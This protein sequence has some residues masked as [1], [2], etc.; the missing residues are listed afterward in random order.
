MHLINRGVVINLVGSVV[1]RIQISLHGF[2]FVNA[3]IDVVGLVDLLVDNSL[4]SHHVLP[5]DHVLTVHIIVHGSIFGVDV[6][7]CVDDLVLLVVMVEVLLGVNHLFAFL[8]AVHEHSGEE[9]Q[10]SEHQTYKEEQH[11]NPA[12]QALPIVTCNTPSSVVSN[13]I[14][15]EEHNSD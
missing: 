8:A 14:Y 13:G 1:V 9:P 5:H 15:Q 7:L 11:D 12:V 6:L 10:Q 2:A 3:L 4:A